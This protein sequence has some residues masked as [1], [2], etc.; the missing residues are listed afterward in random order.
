[1]KTYTVNRWCE[2]FGVEIVDNDGF[3]HIDLNVHE[4]SLEKFAKGISECTI[5]ITNFVLYGVF[6]QIV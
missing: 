4:I 1:M 5:Q 6:N 2:I 3:P